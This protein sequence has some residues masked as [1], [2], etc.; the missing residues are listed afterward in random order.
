MS[1]VN[2]MKTMEW[3]GCD[4]FYKIG[5]DCGE[6]E[7]GPVLHFELDKD[8]GKIKITFYKKI[9]WADYYYSDFI[10]SKLWL[11]I[12]SALRLLFFGYLEMEGDFYLEN[13]ESFESIQEA[14]T[15]GMKKLEQWRIENENRK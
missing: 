3:K 11:R 5:C 13:K 10:L 14:L 12:K 2:V 4:L 9:Y 8:F 15:E 1:S 6:S 7:H